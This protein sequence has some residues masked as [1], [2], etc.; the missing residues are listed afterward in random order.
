MALAAAMGAAAIAVAGTRAADA[1]QTP[2]GADSSADGLAS[3]DGRYPEWLDPAVP[4]QRDFF[5]HANGGWINANPIPP[6]RSYWGVDTLLEQK[7]QVFIRDL[8]VS[9]SR[10]GAAA[11]GGARKLADFYASGMDEPGIEAAGI[12]PLQT[13]LDRIEAIANTDELQ[14]EFA[15]LQMIGVEAPLQ[16]GQMQDFKDSTQVIALVLQSGLGLPNRD[17]YLKSEPNFVAARAEYLGHVARMIELTGES[18]A[19]AQRQS[20]TVMA[21]ET[22][23]ARVSMSDVEQRDPKAIYHPMSLERAA[24]LTPHLNWRALLKN[25]GHP[26]IVSLNIATPEFFKALDRELPGTPLADWKAYLRWQ[27]IDAYAPYLARAFVDEDFRMRR[28]LTGAQQLQPRWLRVL[29]A[30][31]EALG[32]AI[33]EMYVARKFPPAAKS[34]ATAMVEHV[35]DALR[36][37]LRTLQWMT[38]ATRA[39]ALEKL[40]QM[41]LRV[42]YPDRWRDYSALKVER[43]APYA[44]NVLRAREFEQRRQFDKIGKPVDRSEWSMTPQTVNAYYD[45]SMNSLNVPAGILQPPF[46]D[47]GWPDAVNY[48][49]TGAT[50]VGHEMTH[51]FDDEGAK[52]DGH[53]NLKNWWAPADLK[54]FQAATRCVSE[55]FSRYAVPGGLHVQGDLV[56]GEAVADLGGLILAQRALHALPMA[57]KAGAGAQ[58]ASTDQLFFI[59]FA[60][61][62]AGQM[63]PEQAQELVTTDPHPPAEFRTNGTLANVA[64]FQAAFAI[65]AGSPMVKRE[66]CVI[67]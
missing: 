1:A 3:A 10:D 11:D 55:Q 61:S 16:L 58:A 5:R 62:W 67:W 17:Y 48:G 39:A 4:A 54:R 20:K 38:P 37:D 45:P 51:G 64:E 57:V 65:P 42:G 6:D 27:L 31:D 13:E 34:A 15:R 29:D 2:A 63:R 47:A 66:R 14:A 22:R 60:H 12:A 19:A 50:T 23:L 28:V 21:L 8:L 9:L 52:F 32:F 26:E 44:I 59:A 41:E 30:E 24:A 18:A 49:A 43:A 7:N 53:G 35:R 46:F 40:E 36:E 25:V 56:T 33:G